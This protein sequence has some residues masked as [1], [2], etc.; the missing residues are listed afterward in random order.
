MKKRVFL[1]LFIIG[2]LLGKSDV[3]ALTLDKTSV[4]IPAGDKENIKLYAK[5]P[6]DTVKVEFTL[7]F[8]S[9]DI[10]VYFSPTTGIT[11]K[12]PDGIKHTLILSEASSNKTLLGSIIARVVNNPSI[13]TSGA[14][15]HSAAAYDSQG[16][17]TILNSQEITIT[18]GKKNTATTEQN[19][20]SSNQETST[21][22]Q[23]VIKT[24]NLLQEIK[25]NNTTIPVVDDVFTYE[26]QVLSSVQELNLQVIPKNDKSKVTI[27][28]QKIAE[29]VDNKV[30]I[31]VTNGK[32]KQE[33]VVK[34]NLIKEAQNI[35]ID[36]SEFE[37]KNGYK[38]TWVVVIIVAGIGL[39]FGI[40]MN[41]L[42]K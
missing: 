15:L 31:T 20:N 37:P 24:Y 42:K 2:L 27:S 29:L 12:N 9:Y 3:L 17:K 23:E 26:L 16:N 18:I 1:I 8:D 40:V 22:K 6:E 19:N 33:Y 14:D 38:G 41:G 21:T 4:S 30:T 34:I 25:Y 35:E 13:K 11:D 39:F 7:V 32:E 28:N 5:L 36:N 10:P